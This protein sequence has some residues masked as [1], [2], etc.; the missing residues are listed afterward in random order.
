MET[1][2]F[3][4]PTLDRGSGLLQ[5]VVVNRGICYRPSWAIEIHAVL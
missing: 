5:R 1:L 4:Q 3:K 2:R